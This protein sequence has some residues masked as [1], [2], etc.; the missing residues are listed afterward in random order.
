MPNG[1]DKSFRRLLVACA[2][3]RQKFNEWPSQ[4]R[5]H[6]MI[7]QD[8][9]HLFDGEDFE[10]LATHLHVRT[11]DT[12]GISVGGRGVV[13]YADVELDSLDNETVELAEKWLGGG[14][15]PDTEHR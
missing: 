15:R 1:V 13:D 3:Y 14:V 10:R 9:A 6:P 8:L 5:L 12:M 4:A 2:A 7:L 11:R